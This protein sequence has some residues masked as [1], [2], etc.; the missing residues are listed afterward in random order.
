MVVVMQRL[1]H[2]TPAASALDSKSTL[3]F[4]SMSAPVEDDSDVS[5]TSSAVTA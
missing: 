4:G 1:M 5:E 2:P 3:E